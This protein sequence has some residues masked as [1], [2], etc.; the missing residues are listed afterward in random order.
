[1][2]T[3]RRDFIRQATASGL[4]LAAAP[5]LAGAGLFEPK[6]ILILGGTGFL[7]P[8]CTTA[9]L[10][11]GHKVTLFNRGVRE[12]MR[13]E[14]GRPSAVPDGVEVLYG[15]R[16]PEKTADADKKPEER[17]PKSPKGL[18]Q[19]AG[20][21][22]DA[23]IDTSGYFPRMVRASA[24]FL[25]PNVKHYT[26][27][28]SISVYKD[29]SKPGQDESGALAQLS[30]PNIEE[31]GK[32]FSNY[33]GG[34][35]ACE[36]AAE[37]A[38]KGRVANIRPG[39]IVGERDSTARFIYW[40]L[41][42]RRGGEI[43]VPGDP[44]DPIQIIDVRDLAEWC[45]HCI[46]KNIVGVFNATGPEKELSM[47]AMVEGCKKGTG[48]DAAT[49]TWVPAEFLEKRDIGELHLWMPPKGENAGF[50][51]VNVSKA[52]AN[53]LK[54]RSVADTAK[55]TVDWFDSLPEDLRAQVSK[56]AMSAELESKLLGEWKAAK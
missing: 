11:R 27:I 20:R 1:M 18:S 40:P 54:F 17:D 43:L 39:F 3:T 36:A 33:G 15:N 31:F 51:R 53:G 52:V 2:H 14:K 56:T 30:D 10:A 9:A 7:G 25:A 22:W 35:V 41:R 6:T 49:Y 29:N 24:E 34:K 12:A 8:A 46:E 26:F 19:L 21:K 16:D 37:A 42:A 45:V 48:G 55:S 50:H 47:K 44:T 28:S 5:R 38:M 4:A 13:K 23:V 32:D